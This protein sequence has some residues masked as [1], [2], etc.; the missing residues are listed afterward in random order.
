MKRII[1]FIIAFSLA[2]N[3]VAVPIITATS[4]TILTGNTLNI[5]G[6]GFPVKSRNK[7]LLWADAQEGSI[8][9]H[10]TLSN[11][12]SLSEEDMTIV[13]DSTKRWGNGSFRSDV[14]PPIRRATLRPAD[15]S[16]ITYNSRIFISWWEK[17]TI[18]SYFP[19]NWKYGVRWWAGTGSSNYPS[20]YFASLAQGSS[21]L[22]HIRENVEFP[23]DSQGLG[24]GYGLTSPTWR[25]ITA[26]YQMNAT[27]GSSDGKLLI[28]VGNTLV[29]TYLNMKFNEAATT[30]AGR[31]VGA[32]ANRPYYQHV[33]ASGSWVPG[34]Y[35]W[36]TDLALDDSWGRYEIGNAS[37]YAACTQVELQPYTLSAAN[38]ANIAIRTGT[39]TGSKWLYVCDNDNVCN[40]AG[41]LLSSGGL[42]APTITSLSPA[43]GPAAGGT[44]VTLTGTGLNA[45]P[46]I[47]VNGIDATG[48]NYV[49]ATQMTFT[50]PVGSA[51][52]T[53]TVVL[54]N[55]DSQTATY[56]GFSY[57][58]AEASIDPVREVFPW[59]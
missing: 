35:W 2:T 45:T 38:N 34:E 51:G 40:S 4:G 53:A 41:F 24:A 3:A 56:S 47:T 33:M 57:N 19:N 8:A 58:P 43:N 49:S 16:G 54:I 52:T 14:T 36:V 12:T 1:A 26:L 29:K 10:S 5:S 28:Y 21:S 11:G 59:K 30:P 27:I 25:R 46:Q 44:S 17:S 48:E 9:G 15:M 18:S 13:T 22:S 31:T 37:T 32:F 55:P 39:I 20:H 23:T 7:L 6:S 50:A 42:L